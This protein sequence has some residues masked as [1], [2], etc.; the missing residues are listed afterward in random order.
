M[1]SLE[2]LEMSASTEAVPGPEAVRPA[3]VSDQ[4]LAKFLDDIEAHLK[5]SELT[6]NFR[7]RGRV[8]TWL[9]V[10]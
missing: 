5:H 9:R 1:A 7:V 2:S 4:Q 6:H 10:E 8:L 3:G